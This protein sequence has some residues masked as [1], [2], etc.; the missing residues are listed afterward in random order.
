MDQILPA[1]AEAGEN[2]SRWRT[3]ISRLVAVVAVLALIVWGGPTIWRTLMDDEPFLLMRSWEPSERSAGVR[4]L[5]QLH[6]KTGRDA[7][8][9]LG[10]L[11]RAVGD[12][13]PEVRSAAA[14]ALGTLVNQLEARP[15][16]LRTPDETNVLAARKPEAERALAAALTDRAPD[17]RAAAAVVLAQ[18]SR[19][20]G[21][22]SPPAAVLALMNDPS[23]EVRASAVQAI[24]SF[25]GD[26]PPQVVAGLK[27]ESVAVR[28][29]TAHALRAFRGTDPAIPLLLA[30]LE[31][32][33]L[34]QPCQRALESARPTAAVVPALIAALKSR[35]RLARL[36]ASILLG[37]IGPG[38]KAAVPALVATLKEP[39][40]PDA[41]R[42][43]LHTTF[44]VENA[45]GLGDPACAAM[46]ALPR[47]GAGEPAVTALADVLSSGVPARRAVAA[48]ALD[49]L[50]PSAA[51][52]VPALSADV[53]KQLDAKEWDTDLYVSETVAL[54]RIAPG[55]PRAS[56]AV[57][58]LTRAL[59]CDDHRS[60]HAAD[61]LA[62]FGK[63]A[64]PAAA[65]LRALRDRSSQ[66]PYARHSAER[67]LA[68]IEGDGSRPGR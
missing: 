26:V 43:T 62:N 49:Q 46:I 18:L 7:D 2:K 59:D 60:A 32:E 1:G 52:A 22:S 12:S 31:D 6:P 5:A 23:P 30:M 14:Y 68:A 35:D 29:A 8:R 19:R 34:R 27:D 39:I 65:K 51:A 58:V 48:R 28:A 17:V 67:A 40:D 38:A 25:G 13:D 24:A 42:E 47:I 33:V 64:A 63:D 44:M 3:G 21:P 15:A 45:A 10:T 66:D 9:A 54:G 20:N 57:A 4:K 55:S 53:A 56:D 61:A 11:I 41:T 16:K 36:H 37:R 50:G